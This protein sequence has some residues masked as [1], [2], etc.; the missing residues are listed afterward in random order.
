MLNLM[1]PQTSVN[2]LTPWVPLIPV[3]LLGLTAVIGTTSAQAAVS[4][5]EQVTIYQGLASVTRTLPVTAA[6]EQ[7]LVFSCLSPAIDE[8]SISVQAPPSVNVG[9]VSIERLTGEQAAQCQYQ[10]DA[11]VQSQ[12]QTLAEINADLEAAR[13]AKAYLQ[14]L[15]KVTQISVDG[16]VGGNARD[17]ETQA[18]TI[19]K[20]ILALQQQQARAQDALNQLMAGSAGATRNSVTQVSVRTATRTPG[21]VKL[22][23]QVRGASWQPTYQA[24]LNTETEQ[25]S[26]IASAVIA[27][28]TGENWTNI[29]LTLSSVD[30]NQNTTGSLPL[31]PRLSLYEEEQDNTNKRL[32]SRVMAAPIVVVAEAEYAADMAMDGG[33]M[34]P[35][36]SFTV[37]SQDKNGIT[38][39]RLPQRVSIPSDG[40]RVQTVIA[41][42]A[43]KS[44]VWL[45]S[46]PE[47]EL[48]AYWYASAP[49]LTPAWVD[50][51]LQL[52]R[53]DNYVG[54][55]NYN[56][57]QL[58]EQ[59]IGFGEDPNLL[60]K[61]LL[62]ENKQ[63]DK[64]VLNRL[65]TVTST[66]SYQFT[67]QHK[68][69]VRLQVLGSKPIS[70]DEAIKLTVTHTPPVTEKNWND[71]KGMVAWQF[72]LPAKQT[73]VISSTQQISYPASKQLSGK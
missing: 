50:G 28:Q 42:Q 48:K 13:L 41:E 38:E 53:D 52:Y 10:T 16:T 8:G 67:N 59:G 1:S 65:Q 11:K 37:N 30:P 3:A 60:V 64:G 7:T 18:S 25:L 43:G 72:D 17:L 40:R 49:F 9:E 19:N 44:K 12:Q 55:S 69:T 39:Y 24:R 4:D 66:Q 63:G 58:K 5:V 71:N 6:G 33:G 31:V 34:A 29:P 73:Q 70:Q 21:S 23:Y 47:R 35:L 14:N 62:N 54:Q 45:R 56:Y 36:P 32:S 51:S 15:T 61:Q 20:R 22:H 57:Q 26:I 2:S 27:Q 46:T 68:R